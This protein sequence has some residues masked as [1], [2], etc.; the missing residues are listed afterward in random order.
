MLEPALHHLA[1]LVEDLAAAE[2]FYGDLLGLPVERRWPGENGD[3]SVWLRLGEGLLMLERATPGAARRGEGGGGWHLLALKIRAE[4]REAWRQRL[5]AA[6]VPVEAA[7]EYTLYI[8]DPEGNRVGL[9]HWPQ[10]AS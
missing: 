1:L 4:E 5:Q 3:R 9:S 8:R 2:R 7:S 6:G 10:G